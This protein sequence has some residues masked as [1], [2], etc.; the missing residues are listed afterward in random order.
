MFKKILYFIIFV[1]IIIIV[2]NIL[3]L[4][5]DSTD[6]KTKVNVEKGNPNTLRYLAEKR[7]FYVGSAVD[8][9][10]LRSSSKY[11]KI[12]GSQLNMIATENEMKFDLIHPQKSKYNF[13]PADKIIEFAEKNNQVVRGHTLVWA[14]RVP[15]WVQS[16]NYNKEQMKQILKQHIQ[17][18]V[19]HYKGKIYAWDVINEAI[20][21]DGKL[22]DS[23]WLRTIGP[24]YIQLAF[25]WAHEADPNALLFY[26]DNGME[27]N[28]KKFNA[29]YRLLK[30]FKDSNV[31]I[32]GIGYQM[33][34]WIA[35]DIDYSNLSNQFQM[36]R[37]TGLQVQITEMDIGMASPKNESYPS[38]AQKQAEI[39]SK[40]LDTCL[41]NSNCSAFVMWGITDRYTPKYKPEKP[42]IF[43]SEFKPK[44]S[45]WSLVNTLKEYN[46]Q[47]K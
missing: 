25:Q 39:Y 11:T 13:E 43:D 9:N 46:K 3:N 47:K 34:S 4:Q 2:L 15:A 22:N 41:K 5:N 20:T 28:N 30:K 27:N 26:N 40:V 36:L 45:Y 12:L 29:L 7:K 14:N 32:D 8:S 37:E 16:G 21:K 38:K 6:T 19:G 17:T 33:H 23:I 18:V 42:L 35:R 1:I 44:K 31:P 24:E 10:L